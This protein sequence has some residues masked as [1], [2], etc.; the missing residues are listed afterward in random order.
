MLV[1]NSLLIANTLFIIPQISVIITCGIQPTGVVTMDMEVLHNSCDMWTHD[2]PDMYVLSP[3]DLGIHI[4]HI[5][6]DHVILLVP[7]AE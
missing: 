4:S 3:Q 5:P 1:C 2:L 6:L 7:A